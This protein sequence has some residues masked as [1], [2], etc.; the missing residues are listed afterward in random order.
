MNKFILLIYLYYTGTTAVRLLSRPHAKEMRQRLC[1]STS[2][3]SQGAYRIYTHNILEII[4]LKFVGHYHFFSS[5]IIRNI[6]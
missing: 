1:C 6:L 2:L 5:K 4:I 3:F